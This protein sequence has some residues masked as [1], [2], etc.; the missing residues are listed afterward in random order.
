ME[1]HVSE[2]G[3]AAILQAL[4]VAQQLV[5]LVAGRSLRF[6]IGFTE[7]MPAEDHENIGMPGDELVPDSFA[8]VP[9]NRIAGSRQLALGVKVAVREND[10]PVFLMGLGDR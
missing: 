6:E 4:V 8:Q 1:G 3:F 9:F 5:D 2:P 10:G 7:N